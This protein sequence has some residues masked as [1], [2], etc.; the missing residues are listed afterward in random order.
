MA[1]RN[2][3][4]ELVKRRFPSMA[5]ARCGHETFALLDDPEQN[6][7]TGLPIYGVGDLLPGR[8][9]PEVTATLACT[10]CGR[11]EQFL[12]SFFDRKADV[13]DG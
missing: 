13:G 5:C 12:M 10:N 9:K 2:D 6:T 1:S 8:F 4:I 7:Q 3:L 11:I